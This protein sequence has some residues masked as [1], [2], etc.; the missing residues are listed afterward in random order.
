ML[1]K[2]GEEHQLGSQ[3]ST[4]GS[5]FIE[6]LLAH[7]GLRLCQRSHATMWDMCLRC[8]VPFEVF[9]QTTHAKGNLDLLQQEKMSDKSL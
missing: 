3:H 1:T 4:L 8:A 5:D 9:R 7:G 6:V 2:P